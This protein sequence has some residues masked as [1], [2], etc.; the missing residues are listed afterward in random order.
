MSGLSGKLYFVCDDG[1]IEFICK[2]TDIVLRFPSLYDYLGNDVV[3]IRPIRLLISG[4]NPR[5]LCDIRFSNAT[6]VSEAR[7]DIPISKFKGA[8]FV[9]AN[10][11]IGNFIVVTHGGL[12]IPTSA[13]KQKF[14]IEGADMFRSNIHLFMNLKH[15]GSKALIDMMTMMMVMK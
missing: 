6:G 3:G 4:D 12:I 9:G 14:G 5:V 15:D 13:I 8:V 10:Q 11:K 1:T 7:W 2:K